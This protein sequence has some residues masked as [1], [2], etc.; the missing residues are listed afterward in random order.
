MF[1]ETTVTK[2]MQVKTFPWVS[3]VQKLIAEQKG[4]ISTFQLWCKH[5]H[6]MSCWAFP[7]DELARKDT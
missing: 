5:L 3:C 4:R 1:N 2:Y 6:Y 7:L